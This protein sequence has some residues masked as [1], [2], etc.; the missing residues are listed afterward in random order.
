MPGTV[1]NHRILNYVNILLFFKELKRE[2]NYCK[3]NKTFLKA[4][5]LSTEYLTTESDNSAGMLSRK[6]SFPGCP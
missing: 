3:S 1:L 4:I 2:E 6:L 5:I